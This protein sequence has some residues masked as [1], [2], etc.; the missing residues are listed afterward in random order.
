[1]AAVA[2]ALVAI[3]M[4]TC[5]MVGCAMEMGSVAPW[6]VQDVAGLFSDCGGEYVTSTAPF[7]IVP[8][9]A[10]ALLV[11]LFA[12]AFAAVAGMVQLSASRSAAFVVARP[13]EPPE[14]PLGARL[15]L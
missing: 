14:P 7:A 4:P 13:P 1:M 6:G 12:V 5:R 11:S 8:A 3:V 10:D 9:G 2:L 15:R